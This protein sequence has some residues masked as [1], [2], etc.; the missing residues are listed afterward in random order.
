MKFYSGFCLQNEKRL[1]DGFV[2]EGDFFVYG[3]SY[4]AIKAFEA[5]AKE[6]KEGKRVDRLTLLSPAFFQTKPKS[7]KRLQTKAFKADPNRYLH[8]F[9]GSCFSPY[10]NAD[11]ETKFD[12][13]EDLQTL[14]EYEWSLSR[15]LELQKLGVS[16]EVYLGGKDGV[17]DVVGALEFFS[18][19]A[20][21]TFIKEANH[22]LRSN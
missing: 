21:V 7:F 17:I 6:I 15:L 19:V 4:G 16:I 14:L 10:Q 1:F 2:E 5:V 11:V 18:Q 12:T 3:F 13:L 22:F 8:N 9:L 20:D